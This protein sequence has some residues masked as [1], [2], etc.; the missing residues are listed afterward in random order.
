MDYRNIIK[1]PKYPELWRKSYGDELRRLARGILG[2]VTGTN[3]LFFINKADLPADRWKDVTY[4]SIC[5]N[6]RPK[7]KDPNR[8]RITVG[9]DRIHYVLDCITPTV[10]LLTVKILLNSVISTCGARYMTIDIKYFYFNTPM[11][12]YEYMRI[13]ITNIPDDI[14]HQYDLQANVTK[15]G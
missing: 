7:K 11:E 8:T 12:I 13:K 9:G 4:G 3:T 5:V 6:Y 10:D 1:K 2:C 14:I 15:D